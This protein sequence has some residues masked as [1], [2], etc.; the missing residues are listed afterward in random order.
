MALNWLAP[1]SAEAS[2][3]Q[4][5]FLPPWGPQNAERAETGLA[6][7][8][9]DLGAR[10]NS[11]GLPLPRVHPGSGRYFRKEIA[12]ILK[13]LSV[14]ELALQRSSEGFPPKPWRGGGAGAEGE[15]SPPR[16]TDG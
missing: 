14:C 4:V 7:V 5:W 6:F 2:R 15:G 9:L 12:A 1:G 3:V 13:T 11:D 16:K 10:V 8:K